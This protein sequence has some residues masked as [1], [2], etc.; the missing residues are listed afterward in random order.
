MIK[1]RVRQRSE[2]PAGPHA[3]RVD[4]LSARVLILAL[5]DDLGHARVRAPLVEELRL[6]P[7]A[8]WPRLAVGPDLEPCETEASLDLSLVE[9]RTPLRGVEELRLAPLTAGLLDD[10]SAGTR[11]GHEGSL[12]DGSTTGV[13]L[14]SAE[15]AKTGVP[16]GVPNEAENT[17]MKG[18]VTKR[19]LP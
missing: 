16:T 10:Q 19:D 5:R 18:S 14:F 11:D 13:P 15:A 1:P 3:I 8:T 7:A 9:R 17:S 12:D 6:D 2:G 4:L